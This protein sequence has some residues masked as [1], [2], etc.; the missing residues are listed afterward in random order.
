MKTHVFLHDG[1]ADW[2]IGYLLPEVFQCQGTVVPF[3]LSPAPVT[4]MGGLQVTPQ[5]T[6]AELDPAAVEFLVLPG[7]THWQK[8]QSPELDEWV[9]SVRRRQVPVAGICDA[10]L[11]LARV[12][13]LNDVKHTGNPPEWSKQYAGDAYTGEKLFQNTIACHDQGVFTANGCG[14]V[15]FTYLILKHLKWM[16]EADADGWYAAFKHC[17]FGKEPALRPF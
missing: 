15:E 4:S 6:L 1:Y 2:E 17:Q 13:I 5:T 3:A 16:S 11:Y 9:R 10:T 8:F 14:P 7:G 12:G